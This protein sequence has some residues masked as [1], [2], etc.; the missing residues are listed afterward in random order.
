MD[1]SFNNWP[2]PTRL[3]LALLVLSLVVTIG[4]SLAHAAG[5][6]GVMPW[7]NNVTKISQSFTGPLAYGVALI[8]IVGAGA[9][10]IFAQEIPYFL[11]AVCFVVLAASFMCGANA[12]AATMG[13]TGA[14]I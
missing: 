2:S 13:W 10:L 7:D 4:P 14:V 9:V 12:F 6:G 3:I 11:K 1:M 8:G 5:A